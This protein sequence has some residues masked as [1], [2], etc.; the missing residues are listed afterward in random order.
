MEEGVLVL[1]RARAVAELV[2]VA[3]A[4][5]VRAAVVVLSPGRDGK[6][7]ICTVCNSLRDC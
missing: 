3:V 7:C 2:A 6:L 1:V 4:E 5:A